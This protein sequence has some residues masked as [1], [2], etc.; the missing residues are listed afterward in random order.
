MKKTNPNVLTAFLLAAFIPALFSCA[1]GSSAPREDAEVINMYIFVSDGTYRN[2]D[3]VVEEFE[4]RTRGSL[5]IDL[6]IHTMSIH[7]YR[8]RMV[9]I[10]S[11]GT[12][13]DLVFDAPWINM[14]SLIQ[15]KAYKELSGYFD[16]PELGGLRRA[17][18]PEFLDSNRFYGGIYGIPIMNAPLDIQGIF[19][20]KDLADKYGLVIENYDSLRVYFETVLSREKGMIPMGVQNSR[21]FYFMF[22]AP[23]NMALKNIYVLEG[24]TGGGREL[25]SVGISADGRRVTGVSCYGDTLDSYSRYLPPYNTFEGFNRYFLEA[26][27]WNRYIPEDSVMQESVDPLFLNGYAA[28]TEGTIGDFAEHQADLANRLPGAEL[29]FWPYIDE[30]RNRE[31]GVIALSFRAWNYLC[32][33]QNSVKTEKVFQFL[34]WVFESQENND[35][36]SFGLQAS[37][38]PEEETYQFPGY[39]LTW[40]PRFIHIPANLPDDIKG[41]LEYQYAPDSFRRIPVSGFVLDE[42]EIITELSHIRAIYEKYRNALLCGVYENPAAVLREMNSEMESAGLGKVKGE[43]ARQIQAFLDADI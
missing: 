43:I 30:I 34:N 1:A 14:T 39:E 22:D 2:V 13:A 6:N 5:N 11:T 27:Q 20:R 21:G 37:D 32:I 38:I 41:L 15:K 35:L 18:P 17:F 36:F 12:E 8:D 31:K 16:N 7:D 24:I 19:Y 9:L 33:P 28:A 40:N 42:Q 3:S 4:K 10:A 29:G 26:A 25:F 23:L